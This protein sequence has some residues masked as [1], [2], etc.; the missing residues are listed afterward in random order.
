MKKTLII[1]G[2]VIALLVAAYFIIPRLMPQQGVQSDY[3]TEVVRKGSLTAFVGTT[4]S[5][6]SSQS[7][8][9]AWQTSG[10]VEQVMVEKG[11]GVAADE[12][13]AKRSTE[14]LSQ[15][16][17]QAQTELIQAQEA[18]EDVMNN[19]EARANARLALIEAQ[20]ALEDAEKETQSKLYQRASQNT[21]DIAKA[22]LITAEESLDA[23]EDR[24]SQASGLGDDSP[25]YAA[26]LSS[27]AR[28]RQERDQAEYNLRYT[29]ELPDALDV[30]KVYTQLE[31]AQAK[32][33]AA[34]QEW[35]RIKD[36]PDPDDITAAEVRLSSV[37]ATLDLARIDA[38]FAGTVTEAESQVGDLVNAGT[39][40]FR[41]D[42]L[43]RLLVKVQ[44]SEVDINRVEVGQGVVLTF[45]AILEKEY[46]GVV[47]D[48]ASSG[49]SAGG[50][51]NFTVTV[52]LANSDEDI[53]PGMTAA[54]N[55]AV[56][57]LDDGLLVPSRAVRTVGGSRVV[58]VLRNNLPMMV[59]VQ[60]G[61]SSNA[62]VQIPSGDVKEGAQVILNPPS[63]LMLGPGMG[64][65]RTVNGGGGDNNGGE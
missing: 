50:A 59:E 33:L 49:S 38:P 34:R 43:S 21:I 36:G 64:V 40:A 6:E 44:V 14:S 3:Q 45:D 18:L 52:E 47:T 4:G 24:F 65:G 51:V 26:A 30:E 31:L 27:L 32:L 39:A 54:A 9:L 35:E 22:N 23:A 53:R 25:V 20:Q 42:D 2:V 56:S 12:V 29:Q 17:I 62:Q 10:Q 46:A 57:Q 55:I 11:Q 48:I 5:V 8:V 63:H 37:Q 60:Q 13:L 19:R 15:N 1:I 28:A 58:Y 7:A 61:A 41:V 16:I